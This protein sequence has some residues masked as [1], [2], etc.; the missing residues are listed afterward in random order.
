MYGR[1]YKILYDESVWLIGEITERLIFINDCI[2]CIIFYVLF[3]ILFYDTI[4]NFLFICYDHIPDCTVA[5]SNLIR[6]I[7]LTFFVF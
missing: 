5:M 4:E 6:F 2:K 3:R 1:W 7:F